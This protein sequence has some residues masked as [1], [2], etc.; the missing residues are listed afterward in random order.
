MLGSCDSALAIITRRFMP[1][2][3]VM[4]LASLLSHSVRSRST[5]SQCAGSGALAE[6]PAAEAHG[7]P[8]ALE[9][10]GVQLLRHQADLAARR[11]VVAHDVV[12]VRHDAAGARPDDAAD[13]VDERRLAGAVRAEQR[14]DLAALDAQVDALERD[15]AAGVGL[16][17]GAHCHDRGGRTDGSGSQL[18]HGGLAGVGLG[19]AILT[20]RRRSC[21]AP[22]SSSSMLR[23]QSC[24]S[25][26]DS[27]RSASSRPPV[28]QR[29]Q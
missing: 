9:S 22:R 14:E 1:P 2:D 7:R 12:A 17:H 3:S 25:R 13:D 10:I 4:I 16:A 29:A 27:A 5:R 11:T 28:W 18:L 6:Q 15:E 8:D 26:R 23:G 19:T 20:A 21:Q 24:F